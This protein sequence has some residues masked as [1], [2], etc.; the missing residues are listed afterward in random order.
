MSKRNFVMLTRKTKK[1]RLLMQDISAVFT[2]DK[3]RFP[4]IPTF[5]LEMEYKKSDE[6]TQID[7]S[8]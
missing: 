7:E 1:Y 8:T 5:D 4:R 6:E 2:F 3:R